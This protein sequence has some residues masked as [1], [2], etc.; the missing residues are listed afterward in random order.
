MAEQRPYRMS[1]TG[2]DRLWQIKAAVMLALAAGFIVVNWVATQRAAQMCGYAPWLGPAMTMSLAGPVYAP[3]QWSVWWWRWHNAPELAPL[4]PVCTRMAVYPMLGLTALAAGTMA[5]AR[6]GWFGSVSDLHGSARWAKTRDVRAAGLIERRRLVP[7]RIRRLIERLGI[8]KPQSPRAGV[9][10]GVWRR[11]PRA[12]FMRHC[13]TGHVLIFA[14]TREGKGTG[15]VLPTLVTWPHSVLVHDLKGENWELTAGAR[16][17][18]GQLCMKFEPASPAPG[19]ARFNPLAEVRLR[20]PYEV[21]DVQ[22]VVRL[23]L[24]PEGKGLPEHWDRA[25]SEAFEAFILHRLYE[26]RQP[27]LAGVANLL[28]DPARKV[29]DTIENLMGAE[30]DPAGELGWRDA[31]GNPT[32]THPLVAGGMRSLL[33]MAEKERASV[34]SEVKGFLGLYR[35][36][37]VAANTAASDFRIDD[38]VNHRRPLSL[39]IA[40]ALA[41]QQRMRPLL[42][43]VLAQVLNR[44]TEKLEYRNGRAVPAGKRPL[45]LLIDEFASLGRLELFADSLSLIAGYGLKA[46]LISQSMTQIYNAYGPNQMITAHCHTKMAFRP[47][48]IATAREISEVTGEG[49]VRHAH[50]TVSNSGASVSEPEV[51]RPLLTPD[52]VMRLGEEEVLVFTAGQHAVRAA[53]L[54]HYRYPLFSERVGLKP[55]AQSDRTAQSDLGGYSEKAPIPTIAP[56]VCK[57]DKANGAAR[58]ANDAPNDGAF[59]EKRFLSFAIQTSEQQ[60][61]ARGKVA[62]EEVNK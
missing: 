20:T 61:Q 13:A 39:Y 42:R 45:L 51:G 31:H 43:L 2:D 7:R 11:W 47:Y 46:C 60:V 25:G 48:D 16:K 1:G 3:W 26:G 12:W 14:P 24:D 21:R 62:R 49:T 54:R 10:L 34:I 35:D 17:R 6:Q 23:L 53:K 29:N 22:N 38:L 32:A 56:P 58:E 44:L 18:L 5:L 52:E 9:Y 4:W 33:D 50:R 59:R 40:V 8:L 19:L 55:P 27:T 15:A 30:H 28:F 36:P 37:V 41:D 57:T